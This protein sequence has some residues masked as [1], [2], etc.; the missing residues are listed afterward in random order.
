MFSLY[1]FRNIAAKLY[2]Q[3][4]GFAAKLWFHIKGISTYKAKNAF[5]SISS[6][7]LGVLN[8]FLSWL[9]IV[10]TNIAKDLL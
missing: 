6:Y 10:R 4:L 1:D 2:L 8:L 3:I 5:L 9:S 7:H